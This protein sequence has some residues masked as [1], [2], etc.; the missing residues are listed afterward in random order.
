MLISPTPG[1]AGLAESAFETVLSDF[2]GNLGSELAILWRIVSY[3][4]Y[5]FIGV[6]IL[7]R[8]LRRV[9]LK[10]RLIKFKDPKK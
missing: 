3:Y 5:I 7:P 9:Y 10:R 2:V 6:I 1:G 4:P 8:W